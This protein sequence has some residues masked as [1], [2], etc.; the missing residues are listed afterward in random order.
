MKQLLSLIIWEEKSYRL[1]AQ[2][3]YGNLWEA[4]KG[5][6]TKDDADGTF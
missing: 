4:I 5:N 1:L 3:E 2:I 6:A